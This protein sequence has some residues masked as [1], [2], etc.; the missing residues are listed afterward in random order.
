MRVLPR[1]LG[2]D[3]QMAEGDPWQDYVGCSYSSTRSCGSQ[4]L[5]FRSRINWTLG[6]NRDDWSASVYGYRNGGAR[7]L[8]GHR[9]SAGLRGPVRLD[10][11]TRS[12]AGDGRRGRHRVHLDPAVEY[13]GQPEADRGPSLSL[14]MSDEK[15]T[16]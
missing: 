1:A 10:E 11:C 4:P 15:R 8:P 14:P 7:E 13:L 2:Y 6:W 16:R 12:D 9:L 5:A 3:V